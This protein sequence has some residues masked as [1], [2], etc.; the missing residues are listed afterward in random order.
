MVSVLFSIASIKSLAS[1]AAFASFAPGIA[2][3]PA[4]VAMNGMCMGPDLAITSVHHSRP[5]LDASGRNAYTIAVTATNVGMHGQ[6]GNAL[7]SIALAENGVRLDVKGLQPLPAGASQ[8]VTF[9][10]R[11][12]ADAGMGTSPLHFRILITQGMECDTSNDSA[13]LDL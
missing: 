7:D 13:R 10:F 5:H 6:A 9:I 3:A 11:R 1:L 4:Q 12:A 8:T 2:G